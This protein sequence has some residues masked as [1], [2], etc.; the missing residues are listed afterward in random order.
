MLKALHSDLGKPYINN[1][2]FCTNA[3]AIATLKAKAIGK[4]L[5]RN[6][7]HLIYIRRIVRCKFFAKR[8]IKT[9]CTEGIVYKSFYRMIKNQSVCSF[10]LTIILCYH[11]PYASCNHKD[12]NR[13]EEPEEPLGIVTEI[14][15]VI[16]LVAFTDFFPFISKHGIDLTVM[17]LHL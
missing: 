12:T 1:V 14:A 13:E 5:F 15:A 6:T 10:L 17:Y 8:G 2:D 11:H 16:F 9:I 7:R 3:R 4:K